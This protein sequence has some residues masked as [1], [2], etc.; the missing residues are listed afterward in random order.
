MVMS[1]R[2]PATVCQVPGQVP[3]SMLGKDNFRYFQLA[4]RVYTLDGTTA[5]ILKN[6][7]GK[8]DDFELS[9]GDAVALILKAVVL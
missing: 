7:N 6:R 2:A 4:E 8:L 1:G 5:K 3:G 9:K